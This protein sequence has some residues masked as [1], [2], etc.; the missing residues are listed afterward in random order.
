MASEQSEQSERLGENGNR[1]VGNGSGREGQQ[2]LQHQ[3]QH[4]E[5]EQGQE[6]RTY[7][8][9]AATPLHPHEAG[10]RALEA[11]LAPLRIPVFRAS[12]AA[13]N[14][15]GENKNNNKKPFNH[16]AILAYLCARQV[17]ASPAE[18]AVVGDRLGTDVLLAR[19]MGGWSVWVRDGVTVRDGD[20]GD[21]LGDGDGE[22]D[23][24]GIL[25]RMEIQLEKLLRWK[26]LRA[27][28]PKGYE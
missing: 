17:V 2:R 10:A 26:G 20:D 3:H 22:V 12:S 27:P 16:A 1:S 5:Q 21:G 25:A 13:S 8:A 11:V 23:Y 9:S 14:T 7:A 18:V 28:L 24:K 19:L 6:R 4:Q 15:N